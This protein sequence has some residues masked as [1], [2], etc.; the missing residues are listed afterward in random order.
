MAFCWVLDDLKE[1]RVFCMVVPGLPTGVAVVRTEGKRQ[2]NIHL[3]E[4][5]GYL[6]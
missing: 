1:A 3:A 6:K 5:N 4:P 2:K